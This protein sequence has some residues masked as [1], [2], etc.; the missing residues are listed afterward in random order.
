MQPNLKFL[1]SIEQQP[2]WL[3]AELRSDHAGEMGAVFIYKGIL[4]VARDK[5]LRQFADKH[6]ETEQHHLSSIEGLLPKRAQSKFISI[7]K[8][9]GFLVGAIPSIFGAKSTY[10][11]IAAVETFVDTHYQQQIDRLEFEPHQQELLQ[12]LD[13]FRLDEV[14]HKH[15]A[16]QAFSTPPN[17][18]LKSWC[19]LVGFGSELAVSIAKRI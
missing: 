4:T 11:T 3:V 15:E 17:W 16:E 7:W 19:G 9:A 13:S 1:S 18:L 2:A 6:L 10:A 5:K 8:I 12:L 14:E